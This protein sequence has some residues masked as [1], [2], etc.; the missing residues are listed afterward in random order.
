[1]QNSWRQEMQESLLSSEMSLQI[2]HY[3][4]LCSI[5]AN[6]GILHWKQSMTSLLSVDIYGSIFN[7]S[8]H[9]VVNAIL[10]SNQTNEY[11]LIITCD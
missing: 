4:R 6:N 7:T 2:A 9:Q 3:I 8:S 11:E 5:I 10:H 1:M